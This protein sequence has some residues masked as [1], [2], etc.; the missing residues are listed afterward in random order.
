MVAYSVGSK[1]YS[2][3]FRVKGSGHTARDGPSPQ[4]RCAAVLHRRR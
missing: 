1:V 4:G 3:G 2:L